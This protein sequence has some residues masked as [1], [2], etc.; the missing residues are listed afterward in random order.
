MGNM[1]DVCGTCS[2]SD[3]YSDYDVVFVVVKSIKSAFITVLSEILMFVIPYVLLTN[4]NGVQ[5]ILAYRKVPSI[6]LAIVISAIAFVLGTS[7]FVM[8]R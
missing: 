8:N 4:L 7:L 1:E 2:L 6:L 3:L 5:R